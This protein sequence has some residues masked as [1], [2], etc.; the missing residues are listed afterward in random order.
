MTD[1][2][3]DAALDAGPV[4]PRASFHA[5]AV[6]MEENAA[7][8]A[9]EP[10]L[11]SGLLGKDMVNKQRMDTVAFNIGGSIFHAVALAC[12]QNSPVMKIKLAKISDIYRQNIPMRNVGNLDSP[13]MYEVCPLSAMHKACRPRSQW[14]SGAYTRKLRSEYSPWQC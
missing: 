8:K 5:A 4:Q 6:A 3:A 14:H 12:E 7:D 10:D 9:R 2:H 11:R 1:T 13:S